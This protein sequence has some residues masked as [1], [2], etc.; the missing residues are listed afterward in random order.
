[1]RI[2]DIIN[3]AKEAPL[4]P[5]PRGDPLLGDDNIARLMNHYLSP[6]IWNIVI[7]HSPY[8]PHSLLELP[9]PLFYQKIKP[10]WDAAAQALKPLAAAENP[11]INKMIAIA[12][13]Y[14]PD[15]ATNLGYG[16]P[17]AWE[18]RVA[19]QLAQDAK[20]GGWT[21]R[22]TATAAAPA[23]PNQSAE[24]APEPAAEPAPAT[25]VSS[26]Q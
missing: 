15:I 17:P 21:M 10:Y 8:S 4:P 3:E 2:K 20:P 1:M 19:A 5:R 6:A 14:I 25:Q 22:P 12:K 16:I 11:D 9:P 26:L 23:A 7:P 13:R 24:P 18:Q